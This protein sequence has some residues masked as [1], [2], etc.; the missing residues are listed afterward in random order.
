MHF[1]LPIFALALVS[2]A[3]PL[4]ADQLNGLELQFDDAIVILSN[5]ETHVMKQSEIAAFEEALGVSYGEDLISNPL[6]V[7]APA[8]LDTTVELEDTVD[9][10]NSTKSSGLTRRAGA[11]DVRLVVPLSNQDFINWDVPMSPIIQTKGDPATVAI[12][13]G[14]QI[15]NGYTAGGGATLQL[16]PEFLAIE[17]HGDKVHTTT[18]TVLGTV[19]FTIPRQKF[20]L[21]VSQPR[22]FRKRGFVWNGRPGRSSADYWQFDSYNGATFNLNGGQLKWVHGIITTCTSTTYP[23]KFCIGNGFH[24]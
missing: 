11:G 21:V 14:Q 18:A 23:V 1:Y 8:E 5:G 2:A 24:R 20:G 6:D 22:T 10:L 13:S 19:T 9:D 12:A 4:S 17:G 15:A 3:A 7:S 16:V